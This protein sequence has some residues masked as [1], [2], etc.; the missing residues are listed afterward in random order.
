MGI[1]PRTIHPLLSLPALSLLGYSARQGYHVVAG[2]GPNEGVLLGADTTLKLLLKM[3][4]LPRSKLPL[5]PSSSFDF[6]P[7]LSFAPPL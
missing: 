1:A 5:A 3:A 4:G 6:D 2:E 7:L